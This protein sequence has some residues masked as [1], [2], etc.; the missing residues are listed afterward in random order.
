MLIACISLNGETLK[1]TIITRTK[2]VNSI[3]FEKGFSLQNFDLFTTENSFITGEVFAKW[4][5]E[6]FVPHVE[7]KRAFLRS[8]L[9][10]FNDKAVLIMDG[11][12]AHKIDGLQDFL[13]EKRIHV[14]FLVPH[15]SHLTQA[16][17]IGVFAR[18]KSLMMS[19]Q[20]Y[21]INLHELDER[22]VED[23]EA[24][25]RREE[26]PPERGKLLGQFIIQILKAFHEATSPVNV[27]SAFEQAGICS[28][29]D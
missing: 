10:P 17:D 14:R 13:A 24:Y 4:L 21:V 29:S 9:G 27:V 1:A 19:N 25:N 6:V 5:R 11:C 3:V 8:K 20:K 2:T 18:C 23:I 12:S 22:I 16:L 7:A 15:T 26:L 28:R